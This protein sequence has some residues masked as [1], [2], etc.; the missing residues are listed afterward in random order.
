MSPTSYKLD[1]LIK[2]IPVPDELA[3]CVIYS[4]NAVSAERKMEITVVSENLVSYDVIEKYKKEVRQKYS[5]SE[6]ILRIKYENLGID[7]IDINAYYKNL[8]FYVNEIIS[9]VRHLFTGSSTGTA[10]LPFTAC[11]ER[12]CSAS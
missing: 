9:G 3:D 11:T 4:T 7:D 10:F 12:I 6:F 5:L 2:E 1:N 8:V